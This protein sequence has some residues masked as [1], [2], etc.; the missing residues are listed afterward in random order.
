[1]QIRSFNLP[2]GK[3][4]DFVSWDDDLPNINGKIYGKS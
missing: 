1:M 2:L 4:M 3:M